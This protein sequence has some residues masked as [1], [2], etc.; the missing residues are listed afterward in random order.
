[1]IT[2]PSNGRVKWVISLMEKARMRRKEQKYV[3]E[4]C[5][6][7]LEATEAQIA[8]VYVSSRFILKGKEAGTTE[9][10]CMEKL[11]KV[12]WE[13]VTDDV[14]RKMSDTVNPQGILCV[15]TMQEG[16]TESLI[17]NK[18]NPHLLLLE[19]LQDPGNLGTIL[20]TA[21]GAGADGVI[22]S[23][24]SVDIYNPK[25]IRSTMGAIYR[26]PFFYTEDLHA[27]MKELQQKGITI[28]AAALEKA[29]A[30]DTCDFKSG[31][32]ILIG[33]EGNGLLPETIQAAD[34]TCF[35]P[36]EGQVESLN[37]SVAAAILM[38]EVHRQ[39]Q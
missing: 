38:Y 22:L 20:R 11:R 32:A 9:A 23:R 18:K 10:E 4:G 27:T 31:C 17:K 8:E 13:E 6:M 14:Y 25:V 21:E 15:M 19:N 3:V 36:M 12:A 24:D 29:K 37:A 2:S 33:N 7:F 26:V 16:D 30:Y 28:Y 5:K 39:R 34:R 35:I 1:M